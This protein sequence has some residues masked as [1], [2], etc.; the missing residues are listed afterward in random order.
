MSQTTEDLPVVPLLIGGVET[1]GSPSDRFP[2]YSYAQQKD[3]YLAESANAE[4]AKAAADAAAVAFKTWKKTPA[5]DRRDLLLRYADLLQSHAEELAAVQMA[6]T[7]AP[8]LLAK[9]NIQLAVGLIQETAACITSLKGEIPQ[10]ESSDV[11]PLVFTVPIGP[12]LVIAPWN[13]P[14]ILGA[15]NIATAIAAGCSVVFKASENCPKLHHM[16]VTIFEEAGLPKGVVNVIQA[17]RENA[18]EVT[19]AVIAH[20]AIRKV[21]FVGSAAVGRIVGQVCAKHLK[22]IFM[23]LGGKGPAI[24]LD[25]ADL[26]AAAKRCIAG[27][28]LH[29]GQLCFSTERI[30][31]LESVAEEFKKHLI[32]EAESFRITDGVSPR[33]VEACQEKLIDAKEKGATFL[34]GKPEKMGVAKLHPTILMGLTKSMTLWNEE[35][36][37]PSA[38]LFIARDD[39]HSIELANDS[40][41]GLNAAIHTKDFNRAWVMTQELEFGQVHTNNMTPHDEPTF[42]IGGVKGSGWGRNNALAGLRE[43]SETRLMTWSLEGSKFI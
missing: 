3:V 12:V 21:E 25:D 15:R 20:P 8:E 34:V 22:P 38:A 18:P 36:F 35:S 2:V 4:T 11:L 13:S 6:E 19:E 42:P 39:E 1:A 28:Y 26:P 14:I 24:V 32:K 27:A 17:S 23:E 7:S 5:R 30:I 16:L 41:Y 40:K 37:G 29:H 10:G 43:F 9:K 33:I 31:V